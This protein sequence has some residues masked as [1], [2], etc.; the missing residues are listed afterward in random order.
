MSSRPSDFKLTAP[1]SLRLYSTAELMKLPPPT[2][3]VDAHIPY[4]GVV[5]MYGP[6]GEGKS[7]VAIDLALSVAAGL[8]WQGRRTQPGEVVYIAAEGGFGIPQRIR[9]WAQVHGLSMHRLTIAWLLE[10]VLVNDTSTDTMD[11]LIERIYEADLNPSLIIVDTLARCFV[12][13]ENL[14]QDMGSFIAGVDRMRNEFHATVLIVHHTNVKGERE[15]GNTA[16][17]GAADTMIRIGRDA[18]TGDIAVVCDKQKDAEHFEA[19]ELTLQ[20]VP[21]QLSAVVV[22]VALQKQQIILRWLMAGPLSFA[23]LKARAEEPG[24][25]VSLATLKRRLREL[26]RSGEILK[27]NAIYAENSSRVGSGSNGVNP[28]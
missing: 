11:R 3:L 10:S 20:V 22:P 18:A 21:E 6:P 7:F 23:E 15:R 16:L 28:R 12:G 24:S 26:T 27:E 13:D 5:C 2:W 4:G 25:G 8:P 9:A 19:L 17:R 1:G 14:Q